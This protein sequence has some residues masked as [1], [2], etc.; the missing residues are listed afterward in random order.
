[1]ERRLRQALGSRH[2]AGFFHPDRWTFGQP[3]L[4][5]RLIT[6]AETV[7]GVASLRLIHCRRLG[8][9]SPLLPDKGRLACDPLQILR[10]DDNRNLPP[11][12]P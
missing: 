3:L 4:L 8:Q 10:L 1:V 6:R 5:S 9:V 7:A 2:A 11:T 12:E